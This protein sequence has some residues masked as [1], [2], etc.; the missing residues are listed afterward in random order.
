MLRQDHTPTYM[1]SVVVDDHD[2]NVNTI[3]RGDDHFNN[4]FRHIQIY[5]HLE[6]KIPKYAH[7]PLIH[8]E[9]G[10]KLSKRHG[11]FNI[12][13][14]K[15]TGYLPKAIINSLILLGWSPKKENEIIDIEEIIQ[16]F[17]I[18][19][20]SKSSSLFDHKKLKYF[21]SYYIQK[22]DSFDY[23]I[24]F[25][26]KEKSIKKYLIQD[27]DKIKE[28]F[29]SYKEK[30]KTLNEFNEI[31]KI[32]FEENFTIIPN[33]ILNENFKILLGNFFKNL[34]L[35]NEWKNDELE[36]CLKK[37]IYEKKIKFSSFGKP[38]RYILTNKVDGPP[39]NSIIAILGKKNTLIRMK[40][41]INR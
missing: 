4:A 13:E 26:D 27:K 15:Q 9:D 37:F 28:I 29:N 25:I 14:L 22:E 40:Q 3:I 31:I 1:L 5:K 32:Y 39:I 10:S 41:Y 30:V 24:K 11:T 36:S 38:L 8:G 7:M 17:Q 6:W 16:L 23:F 34:Q 12:N 33:K 18:K 2:M 21:N 19:D 20:L 35:I